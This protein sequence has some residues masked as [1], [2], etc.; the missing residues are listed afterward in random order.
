MLL[1]NLQGERGDDGTNIELDRCHCAVGQIPYP[2]AETSRQ[3]K[4]RP[5]KSESV[6]LLKISLISCSN[7]MHAG[8]P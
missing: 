5:P 2:P 8:N 3:H 7:P 4:K 1:R 6:H